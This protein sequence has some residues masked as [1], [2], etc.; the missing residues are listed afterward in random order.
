MYHLEDEQL[1]P[2]GTTVKLDKHLNSPIRDAFDILF[3]DAIKLHPGEQYNP[4]VST[5]EISYVTLPLSAVEPAR[6]LILILETKEN[7]LLL[8]D[9]NPFPVVHDILGTLHNDTPLISSWLVGK[10]KSIITTLYDIMISYDPRLIHEFESRQSCDWDFDA[11]ETKLY[12]M[13]IVM[14]DIRDTIC[15]LA[16]NQD[17]Y[18]EFRL[19]PSEKYPLL[20]ISRS[21]TLFCECTLDQR[22]PLLKTTGGRLTRRDLASLTK[23]INQLVM[24]NYEMLLCMLD[25]TIARFF[26]LYSH[27]L[28][29]NNYRFKIDRETLI[30]IYRVFDQR[31]KDSG[32]GIYN[33]VKMY[34]SLVHATII[35]K[36]DIADTKS[37][38][39]T[40][41]IKEA[42]DNS[43]TG[44]LELSKILGKLSVEQLAELHG[45]HRHWGHPIVDEVA[46]CQKVKDIV[47][48]RSPVSD[49]TME[50]I[51][52]LL[53]K[54][55]IL[56][57]I[58]L[59]G[60]WPN[61]YTKLLPESSKLLPMIEKN[62]RHF[63]DYESDVPLSEWAKL[64]VHDELEFDFKIDYLEPTSDKA[65]AP[66]L[67]E[68][69]TSYNPVI[70]GIPTSKAST[71]RRVLTEILNR[72]TVNIKEICK[73]VQARAIPED[74]YHIK[75]SPKERELNGKPRLFAMF[76]L[77]MRLLFCV[78]EGNIAKKLFKYYPQQS[79]NLSEDKLSRRVINMST[80]KQGFINIEILIG[81][82][83]TSWNIHWSIFNTEL[84]ARFIS[85]LFGMPSLYEFCHE[86]FGLCEVSL[87]S[88]L[89]VPEKYMNQKQKHHK[90]PED[91]YRWDN[92]MGGFEG[93]CQKMWTIITIGLLLVVEAETGIKAS[94][95]GQGD[96][97][98]CKILVPVENIN[99]TSYEEK[100][101]LN[102]HIIRQ[103]K[104]KFMNCL[105]KVANSIGI[106]LKPMESW[107]S[108]STM[109]FCKE[110]LVNGAYMSQFTKRVAR[111]MADV[112]EDYPTF[113][114]RIGSI[115]SAGSSSA[116]KSYIMAIP[117]L[118]AQ[119]ETGLTFLR[120][121]SFCKKIKSSQRKVFETVPFLTLFFL[122]DNMF[123]GVPLIHLIDYEFRGHPD[124]ITAYLEY[125]YI[126][127]HSTQ[128]KSIA[129]KTAYMIWQWLS[130]RHYAR[131][132]ASAELLVS[133]PTAANIKTP[134][135]INREFK[136]QVMQG[137][138]SVKNRDIHEMFSATTPEYDTE[139]YSYLVS[140]R[141]LYPRLL[142][143]IMT[144]SPTG[145]RLYTVGKIVNTK[146][147]N[148]IA[149][150]GRKATIESQIDAVDLNYYI[151]YYDLY[152][153]IIIKDVETDIKF[154]CSTKL[155]D[156]IRQY[157]FE[158]LLGTKPICGVTMPHPAHIYKIIYDDTRVTQESYI[159]ALAPKP[160]DINGIYNRGEQ[161][162][163][164]GT[165]T[166]E[167]ISGRIV[168]VSGKS[169]P[170]DDACR[171]MHMLG[172]AVAPEGKFADH[173]KSLIQ[174]RTNVPL[175]ILEGISGKNL[176]GSHIHRT[177]DP[178]TKK[179][180]RNNMRHSLSTHI[181]YS[182]DKLGFTARGGGDFNIQPSAGFLY[183]TRDIL[184]EISIPGKVF[185]YVR[186]YLS[187][188][189]CC[190]EEYDNMPASTDTDGPTPEIRSH[191]PL[192]YAGIKTFQ[193]IAIPDSCLVTYAN[194]ISA[195]DAVGYYLMS[196]FRFNHGSS[197]ISSHDL[198]PPYVTR[199]SMGEIIN[200]GIE[201]IVKSFAK[202]LTL[203]IN[204]DFL[205][206][207][208]I[209]SQMSAEL[210]CGIADLALVPDVLADVCTYLKLDGTPDMY[211]MNHQMGKHLN[212]ML[213]SEM[214][215]IYANSARTEWK[216]LKFFLLDNIKFPTIVSLW[217]ESVCG[218]THIPA[219]TR[220][221]VFKSIG[222][223][224]KS[225]KSWN[226]SMRIIV[227]LISNLPESHVWI[228]AQTRNR[229][230]I[231]KHPPEYYFRNAASLSLVVRPPSIKTHD[232]P[233]DPIDVA[234]IIAEEPYPMR[235]FVCL[236]PS[237]TV[238]YMKP[239][240]LE[241]GVPTQYRKKT[242]MDQSSRLRGNLSTAMIKY[243][244][245]IIKEQM[246][247]P[248]PIICT[249]DGESS[250]GIA[251]HRYTG[252]KIYYNSLQSRNILTQRYEN[253][254]PGSFVYEREG[255]IGS[256]LSIIYGGDLTDPNYLSRFLNILP[257][258]PSLLTCDAETS[259]EFDLTIRLNIY[260][261]ILTIIKSTKPSYCILKDFLNNPTLL[262]C[263]IS[264]LQF[265]Y[266]SVKVIIPHY[267]SFEGLECFIVC[268]SP[269]LVEA[270]DVVHGELYSHT[271]FR[272]LIPKLTE[273]KY[274][275]HNLSAPFV[276]DKK[277]V[278][279]FM[280]LAEQLQFKCNLHSSILRVTGHQPPSDLTSSGVYKWICAC[281]ELI[282]QSIQ[283]LA[284]C[285]AYSTQK[286][287]AATKVDMA[288]LATHKS[289]SMH[290][291][292]HGQRLI[293]II[294]LKNIL[295]H[296]TLTE[297]NDA[298][299]QFLEQ[300]PGVV[301]IKGSPVY[302]LT[303]KDIEDWRIHN[304]KPL[305]RIWGHVRFT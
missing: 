31:I 144:H 87:S 170:F 220:V 133:N 207:R 84:I 98:I 178:A 189:N 244:Q 139:F 81:I 250:V 68:A 18:W 100:I 101:K 11:T 290:M 186:G 2:I 36:S 103:T 95:I 56:E 132:V 148:D 253:F 99:Y 196:R 140:S 154:K 114:N 159:S 14:E 135:P 289:I 230:T 219:T 10:T 247:L 79:M 251:I 136:S 157:S 248:T 179:D 164:V 150:Q 93:I 94:I 29:S 54:Q 109:N 263:F 72:D 243:M 115:Q 275:K 75:L 147:V 91:Q 238:N 246:V 199:I 69:Q 258:S 268:C 202:Y 71:S 182:S 208:S 52:G 19:F 82:D 213:I 34:E 303:A 65:I 17:N 60:R 298:L 215:K 292:T 282:L 254:I 283:Q 9:R 108:E 216:N 272:S 153:N 121:T 302:Q 142:N 293:S 180:V 271:D 4:I 137:L 297:A 129:K 193:E 232:R 42:T 158:P 194:D 59:H 89:R 149:T 287:E 53:N 210:W 76:V 273:L 1:C 217:W 235:P 138:R 70:T 58:N 206:M 203:Y 260:N 226:A 214:D 192:L 305:W 67:T 177:S 96:N 50:K 249:A 143:V 22:S 225:Q 85:N 262:A 112:N 286:L 171:L 245:I 204:K 125:I 105:D 169:R 86:F 255:V 256:A 228:N 267:S 57:F 152:S 5:K 40:F 66:L 223:M 7:A 278:R 279:L 130:H 222:Q 3:L 113:P 32:N 124:P 41:I 185:T 118:V 141:P 209:I 259:G 33:Q 166:I 277:T 168:T 239:E 301:Y 117:W 78:L 61:C 198:K 44:V 15:R 234:K 187:N 39:L 156:D 116:Q 63:N 23:V 97:Q 264:A 88:S 242:R 20:L 151:H 165:K 294:A 74:W 257:E 163:F 119:L 48:T 26:T 102:S 184:K 176:F 30:S 120:D 43:Y 45:I 12:M 295:L 77:E 200:I 47:K 205:P 173:I 126:I 252:Q 128:E 134:D 265:H 197:I 175:H 155:A 110:I 284:T 55:F 183:L 174:C 49:E 25:T 218:T 111:T 24:V 237:G 236:T 90:L 13:K 227:Q 240:E 270:P 51:L 212:A 285:Y 28:L 62:K 181:A 233:L 274:E 107:V 299:T 231:M 304:L 131:G 106:K 145:A 280:S 188:T 281:S 191:N 16:E 296:T 21:M 162:A 229:I 291:N 195:S 64:E 27:R 38:F 8:V 46:G 221:A 224:M 241:M 83:F 167:K 73:L 92:H 104:D 261:A 123:T 172:F 288:H 80:T 122:G 269:R 300:A 37:D 266:Y 127:S 201:P 160:I 35:E 211:K 161:P 190:L 276:K 146:T 6:N